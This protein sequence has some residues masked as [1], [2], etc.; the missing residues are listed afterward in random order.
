MDKLIAE[1]SPISTVSSF[2]KH[3]ET[4]KC[5][6]AERSNESDAVTTPADFANLPDILK[7]S[8]G[9]ENCTLFVNLWEL[10]PLAQQ[11]NDAIDVITTAETIH[12]I[13]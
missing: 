11:E 13:R 9:S 6:G 7:G 12:H 5:V 1:I 3:L 2:L 8:L 4:N 10:T